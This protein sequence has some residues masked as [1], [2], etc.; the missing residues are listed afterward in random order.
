MSWF[1]NVFVINLDRRPDRWASVSKELSGSGICTYRRVSAVDGSVLPVLNVKSADSTA[2][3]RGDWGCTS[4]HRSVVATAVSEKLSRYVVF[5]DDVSLQ[6]SIDCLEAYLEQIPNDWAL[7]YLGC[8][9]Q[10]P[11]EHVVGPIY[12]PT[13]AYT[14][15]AMVVRDVIY[16]RLLDLWAAPEKVDV[17]LA[18]LQR[19][20]SFYCF[21]PQLAI[22][23]DGHSDILERECSYGPN[24]RAHL[25]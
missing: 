5:E 11:P 4:S 14:T 23:K 20:F 19:E 8:T 21:K 17:A 24:F 1:D 18:T 10:T 22:Q 25:S 9:H 12:K 15:H 16:K 7:I 13:T 6:F 2:V 3:S